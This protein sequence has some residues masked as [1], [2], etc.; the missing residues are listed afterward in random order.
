MPWPSAAPAVMQPAARSAWVAQWS[1]LPAV[2]AH[3]AFAAS[4]VELFYSPVSV[5]SES[6]RR[7][8]AKSWLTHA[9][10]S[11]PYQPAGAPLTRLARA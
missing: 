1:G 5:A 7:S 2:A 10:S 6:K 8:C 4:L 3:S 9:G 11:R